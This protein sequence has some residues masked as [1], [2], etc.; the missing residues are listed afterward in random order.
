MRYKETY[1]RKYNEGALSFLLILTVLKEWYKGD[2][3]NN[4][5]ALLQALGMVVSRKLEEEN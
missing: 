3:L 4:A 2:V 5:V 1:A